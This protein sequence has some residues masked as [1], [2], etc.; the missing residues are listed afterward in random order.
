VLLLSP[1]VFQFS[2]PG[3]LIPQP[4]L[5]RHALEHGIEVLDLYDVFASRLRAGLENPYFQDANHFTPLGHRLAAAAIA[6]AFENGFE[7]SQAPPTE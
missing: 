7:T 4:A 5:A 6:D 2:D 1:Y 3:S